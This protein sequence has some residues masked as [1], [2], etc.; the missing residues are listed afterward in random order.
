MVRWLGIPLW[1]TEKL[2]SHAPRVG[3][4]EPCTSATARGLESAPTAATAEGDGPD[5]LGRVV[6]A[7]DELPSSLQLVRPETVVGWHRHAFRRYCAWKSRRR[8]GRPMIS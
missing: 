4:G 6:E 1:G 3:A 2:C 7:S 8:F 5:F